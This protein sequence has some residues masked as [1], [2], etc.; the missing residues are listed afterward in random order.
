MKKE[1]IFRIT[2]SI[3]DEAE[4]KII[5]AL[6][7]IEKISDETRYE[8]LLILDELRENMQNDEFPAK[9]YL[10]MGMLWVCDGMEPDYIKDCM[11]NMIDNEENQE[12]KVFAYLYLTALRCIQLCEPSSIDARQK[13]LA[14][15]FP[16]RAHKKLCSIMHEFTDSKRKKREYDR[17]INLLKLHYDADKND[18]LEKKLSEI[19]LNEFKEI[20]RKIKEDDIITMILICSEKLHARL[21]E[22]MSEQFINVLENFKSYSRFIR[23]QQI[24][25]AIDNWKKFSGLEG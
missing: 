23:K 19:S 4:P 22:V 6:L 9:E 16:I 24:K 1:E 3:Y 7:R 21:I 5:E 25:N 13:Y 2:S 18:K 12:T 8:G 20:Y 11:E 14:S 10:L 17:G 15:L